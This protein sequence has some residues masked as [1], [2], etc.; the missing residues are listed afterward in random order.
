MA[1][2][3]AFRYNVHHG[4]HGVNLYDA[5][6][7]EIVLYIYAVKLDQVLSIASKGVTPQEESAQSLILTPGSRLSTTQAEK[8]F[9]RLRVEFTYSGLYG[10]IEDQPHVQTFQWPPEATEDSVVEAACQHLQST[11]MPEDVVVIAVQS[12]V[13]MGHE[14]PEAKVKIKETSRTDYVM[15][16]RGLALEM[17]DLLIDKQRMCAELKV[18][19]SKQEVQ[20]QQLE[21][22]HEE[23]QFRPRQARPFLASMS[24]CAMYVASLSRNQQQQDTM[25]CRL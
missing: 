7:L 21:D 6:L 20:L 19:V 2:D 14:W 12:V 13:W 3:V 9:S 16:Y 11:Y 23:S 18:A 4:K 10:D 25:L 5:N 17:V 1:G 24:H 22:M 8:V 15:V